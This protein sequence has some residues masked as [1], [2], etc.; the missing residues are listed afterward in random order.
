MKNSKHRQV[1]SQVHVPRDRQERSPG[2]P[3]AGNAIQ[4]KMV[5]PCGEKIGT[6][7]IPVPTEGGQAEF[8]H[9]THKASGSRRR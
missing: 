9:E 4:G 3:Y 6:S 5:T 7:S 8:M 2:M 1:P